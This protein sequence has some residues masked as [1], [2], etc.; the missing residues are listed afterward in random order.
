MNVLVIAAHPDDEILGAGGAV[1]AHAARGDR[2]KLA[3]MCEGISMRYS[4]ERGSEVLE[5]SRRAA[6]LLGVSEIHT[7]TLPDQRL[8]TMAVSDVAAE[9]DRVLL[10]FE[11]E[12]VYTHFAG[13]LNRDHRVLAEATMIAT[14]PFAAP[15]VREVLMFETPSSTEWSVPQLAPSFAPNVF[16]DIAP[17]LEKKLEAFACYTAEVREY[18]HPRSIQALRERARYWGSL[19]NRRAA[20]PFAVV[21]SLR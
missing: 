10:G 6:Q 19:V 16:V 18:P 4:G 14:R 15:S 17:F 3:I 2:V 5:Q 20:E 21:R 13:D 1:A 7:G 11:A 8:D 9:I 12:V